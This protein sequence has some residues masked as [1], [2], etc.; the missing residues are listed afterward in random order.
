MLSD[1][2]KMENRADLFTKTALVANV[3]KSELP[4][5]RLP[6]DSSGVVRI[7]QQHRQR[8]MAMPNTNGP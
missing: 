8:W 2:K 6:Y 3:R 4:A 7:Q 5:D 1:L